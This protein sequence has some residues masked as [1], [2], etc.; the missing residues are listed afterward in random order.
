MKIDRIEETRYLGFVIDLNLS[1]K[2]H[3]D[4]V[5]SKLSR[6]VGILRRVKNVFPT[7]VI[8]MLYHS[9]ITPYIYYCCSL[10]ASNFYGNFKKVQIQQNK[11]LRAIGKYERGIVSTE[12]IFRKFGIL[13]VGQIRDYQIETFVYQRLNNIGPNEGA[14][15]I[16]PLIPDMSKEYTV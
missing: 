14:K 16:S 9:L 11:V 1:W 7:S 12:S 3:S 10:W 5:S 15:F 8:I 13:N 6:G 4:I 2:K